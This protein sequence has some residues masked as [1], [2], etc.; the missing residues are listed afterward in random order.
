[1][2]LCVFLIIPYTLEYEGTDT[3]NRGFCK[4][5]YVFLKRTERRE[6]FQRDWEGSSK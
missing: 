2:K 6:S 3:E 5:V 1:M 4:D